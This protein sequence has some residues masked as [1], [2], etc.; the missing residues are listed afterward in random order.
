MDKI[1]I[2]YSFFILIAYLIIN[3]FYNSESGIMES[4]FRSLGASLGAIVFSLMISG[5]AYLFN[6][7]V[8]PNKTFRISLIALFV[9]SLIGNYTS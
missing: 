1:S 3:S 7:H 9:L 6:G 4:V 2:K 5:V 8:F